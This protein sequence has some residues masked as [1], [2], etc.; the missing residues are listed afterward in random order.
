MSISPDMASKVEHMVKFEKDKLIS[1]IK[2]K[3]QSKTVPLTQGLRPLGNKKRLTSTHTKEARDAYFLLFGNKERLVRYYDEF[4]KYARKTPPPIVFE[5][6]A[7]F[8]PKI[9]FE[10]KYVFTYP[11]PRVD[12]REAYQV[13]MQEAIYFCNDRV[14]PD[15][16][17]DFQYHALGRHVEAIYQWD[18][19]VPDQFNI[20]AATAKVFLSDP[21]NGGYPAIKIPEHPAGESTG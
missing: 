15:N 16:H 21:E 12:N 2:V 6:L 14:L 9:V 3:P 20:F 8:A 1:K 19:L 7:A 5:V 4:I 13:W 17:T 10:E 18:I 11:N